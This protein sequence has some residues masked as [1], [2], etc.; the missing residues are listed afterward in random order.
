MA[1]FDTS[2]VDIVLSET[3]DKAT[4]AIVAYTASERI[5]GLSASH[6]RK[7]N[8]QNSLQYFHRFLGLTPQCKEQIEHEKRYISYKVN[9][10]EKENCLVIPLKIDGKNDVQTR[11][12]QVMALLMTKINTAFSA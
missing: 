8:L 1:C 4:P 11:P 6:Q 2:G 7:R 9:I 12:E 3:S 5:I 10:D